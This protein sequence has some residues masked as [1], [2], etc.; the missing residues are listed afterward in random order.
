MDRR[1]RI[2]VVISLAVVLSACQVRAAVIDST[3]VGT[4]EGEWG[5]PGNWNPHT[6]PDNKTWQTF[7]V[8]I[9]SANVGA[10][11]VEVRLRDNRTVDTLQCFGNIDLGGPAWDWVELTLEKAE[12]LTNYGV[13]DI[14]AWGVPSFGIEGNLTNAGGAV[15]DLWGADIEGNVNNQAGAVIQVNG[16]VNHDGDLQNSGL[17]A[18]GTSHELNVDQHVYNAG[19]IR[20]Y[21]GG[22]SS[23][24]VLDNSSTGE[25]TGFG[26]AYG[27]ELFNEGR[28]YASAGSLTLAA[29]HFVENSG[30]IG[31]AAG[32]SLNVV[33]VNLPEDVN[34]SGTLQV[35]AGGALAFDC[36]VV[37]EPN[38]VVQLLG[39][40][41][42]AQT[43]TQLADA[44]FEGF[45]GITG[46]VIIEPNAA[47]KLTGPTN[48]VG[49]VSIFENATLQISDGTTLI[50]GQT[51][52]NGTIHMK[53]GRIIPQGGLSGNCKIIWEP[54]TYSNVADFNLD[55]HVD[56]KD[57]ANFADT[58]LW[59]PGW[60]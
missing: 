29:L 3:W 59:Q 32:S 27:R 44:T 13:L 23:D 19:Q 9:D 47:I 49:N 39:G 24:E 51:T 4:E 20:I 10:E 37:N 46:D 7:A 50:T 8:T 42:A 31:N 16:E 5:D 25:I 2:S 14:N 58:W 56:I 57:F 35:N 21:G 60:H 52:C 15:L 38:G 12:G 34:N 48:I 18:I 1:I 30:V 53:G 55:G 40:S 33:H 45:G 11:E 26:V 22:C 36:N 28:I 41:F 17:I 43:M 54:G 6:V